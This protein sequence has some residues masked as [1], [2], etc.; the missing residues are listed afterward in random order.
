MA[1]SNHVDAIHSGIAAAAVNSPARTSNDRA[2]ATAT[3]NPA[4]EKSGYSTYVRAMGRIFRS[5][6]NFDAIASAPRTW[7]PPSHRAEYAGR[8]M[9]S[10][11]TITRLAPGR[12]F[13]PCAQALPVAT[14]NWVNTVRPATATRVGDRFRKNT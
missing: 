12:S 3:S 4:L 8:N 10:S 11:N 13:D 2:F 14:S 6:A 7:A 1:G 5:S 9:N